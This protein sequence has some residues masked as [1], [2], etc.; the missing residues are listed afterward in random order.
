MG[1][2]II[3]AVLGPVITGCVSMMIWT[4]KKNTENIQRS[5]ALMHEGV[6]K[7]ERKIESL[8]L[9]VAKKY[10]TT[11]WMVR[12]MEAETR[13]NDEI[14]DRL[15]SLNNDL[16]KHIEDSNAM[17]ERFRSDIAEIKDMQW[18]MR[19]DQLQKDKNM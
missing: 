14:N 7:V 16:K 6:E 3:A 12:Q 4:S 1:P 17:A 5:I 2:E 19:V 13:A 15:E 18:Q 11:E 8:G 9:E 10:V